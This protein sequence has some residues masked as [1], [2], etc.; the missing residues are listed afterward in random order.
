MKPNT[1]GFTLIELMIAVLL[2]SI[3]SGVVISVLNSSGYQGKARD[4]QRYG[5]LKRIQTALELRFA[6]TRNYP[7]SGGAGTYVD[8][9]VNVTVERALDDYINPVPAD[10]TP[11]HFY[12]YA[13]GGTSYILVAGMEITGSNTKCQ[14][15][16]CGG[17]P[18]STICCRFVNP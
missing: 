3:L 6:D 17:N 14:Y 5:D 1:K 7:S 11:T 15:T 9:A 18:G 4:A 13:S 16:T 8:P 2:L 12:Q 10:P